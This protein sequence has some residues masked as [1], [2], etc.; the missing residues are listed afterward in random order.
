MHK[1]DDNATKKLYELH[2]IESGR[3][4]VW[5]ENRYG[6]LGIGGQHSSSNTNTN[7]NNNN[8][9]NN[10]NN[11]NNSNGDIIIKPTCVK[12]LK[13]LGLKVADISFGNDWSV[14]LTVSNE[15]FFT[16]RNIFASEATVSTNFTAATV[17]GEAC[18]I[19]R[20]PFRLEEFDDCLSNSEE[21]EN[22]INVLAG[23]EHFVLLTSF[24]RLIG[25]G[26]N[27]SHQLGRAK[28]DVILKP[29]EIVLDSP[30]QQFTCGPETTLV[31]TQKGNLY[32][33]GRLNEFVF[34]DFTELQKNLASNEQ[35]IFMH[36]SKAS[37]IFIVTNTGSIYRSYESVR[38]KSLIFQRFY[39]Y[40]SEENGPIWKLLKGSS[41]YA[42][43]TKANKFYTTFSES[44][45]HLK[46]FREI[47]KFKNLRLLDMTLGV[48][49]ILVHGIPRSSTMAATIGPG[50][51]QR[52]MTQSMIMSNTTG[53]LLNRIRNSRNGKSIELDESIK[54]QDNNDDVKET[55]EEKPK[56]NTPVLKSEKEN[57][58]NIVQVK[59]TA[60]S[61][62][63]NNINDEK[64]DEKDSSKL[65]V[66]EGT[67]DTADSLESNESVLT[68]NGSTSTANTVNTVVE[69]KSPTQ[70][71][72][73]QASSIDSIKK[74]TDTTTS[75]VKSGRP[76][77][78]Y[79]E[80]TP[81]VSPHTTMKKTPIRNF[82]YEA[83]MKHDYIEHTSPALVE[84][85]ENI[86]EHVAK[87]SASLPGL[88]VSMPTPPT[89]DDEELRL[90][91]SETTDPLD[92]TVTVN[93]I[94]F[95]NNGIDVT[96][97]VKKFK[98]EA[99]DDSL[100]ET[101]KEEGDDEVDEDNEDNKSVIRKQAETLIEE[102]EDELDKKV[103]EAKTS[104]QEM[105]TL[106]ASKSQSF[107]D[108]VE[109]KLIETKDSIGEA[110]KN[111]G[112]AVDAK[113]TGAKDS[114]ESVAAR[115][116]T[117]ARSAAEIVSDNVKK[118]ARGAKQSMANMSNSVATAGDE[119]KQAVG[120]VGDNVAKTT[121]ETK[122]AM[123]SAL[124]KMAG[125]TKQAV[126]A[127][128]SKIS[129]EVQEA[130]NSLSSMLQGRKNKVDVQK[131]LEEHIETET[132]EPKTEA[133]SKESGDGDK[134]NNT[135]QSN[136]TIT[137]GIQ[138]DDERTTASA[139]SN[140]TSSG[141]NPFENA[142]PFDPELDAMVQ[143]GKQAL[144][145]EL[146]AASV[147]A[148]NGTNRIVDDVVEE[149]SKFSKFLDDMREKSKSLSCRNEKSVKIIEDQPPRYSE[150]D[151][152]A[153]QPING[154]ANGSKVCTIL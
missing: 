28:E 4:F 15:L 27:H 121:G 72:K 122:E 6:Q 53:G 57:E 107:S 39:D 131:P 85:L 115:A 33:T 93:E 69:T 34:P 138:E 68:A 30:V 7:N 75:S 64:A 35:I 148:E 58:E 13:T 108:K 110:V 61:S 101:D 42:V 10:N 117:G 144:R 20:K 123:G 116:A 65:S 82:S 23:N 60:E 12:S 145:E 77:T 40:D 124:R 17:N 109:T 76:R 133:T 132:D 151:E 52:Y 47:S 43:L 88:T 5:G 37:E 137:T 127:V 96:A 11:N 112:E 63:N 87:G 19:I 126:G 50:G 2:V 16:G 98:S 91:I 26:N 119:A 46:T 105:E 44:G 62:L 103:E 80:S 24:G 106:V 66:N 25:W 48:R 111:A 152:L 89:E 125:D 92:H 22:F 102:L 140:H 99:S 150:Q 154:Q 143:R 32:L 95:I 14:I 1:I 55:I 141:G 78:P 79:P 84:S 9:N 73:S 146:Q 130:K 94:R 114:M 134:S 51:D 113:L 54:E 135:T 49:H 97:N 59:Q 90:E 29:H 118:A 31:L 8:T 153:L 71:I 86:P 104:Q 21:T 74:E 45:H 129:T 147:A 149:K 136:N 81:H 120:Q 36:I 100:G 38:N 41:F 18:E 67:K 128:T 83:A 142:I 3:L 56:T 70:S 139:N